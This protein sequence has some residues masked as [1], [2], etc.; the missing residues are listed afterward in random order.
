MT[1]EIRLPLIETLQILREQKKNL[2]LDVTGYSM[3]PTLQ[4]GDKIEVQLCSVEL[5]SSY[6]ILVY[7]DSK[8]NIAVHRLITQQEISVYQR[9]DAHF[10]GS[11]IL[12]DQVLGK[13]LSIHRAGKSIQ[14]NNSLHQR[15]QRLFFIGINALLVIFHRSL[16]LFHFINKF[17]KFRTK[18]QGNSNYW[19]FRQTFSKKLKVIYSSILQ[20]VTKTD[21]WMET[22]TS[23]ASEKDATKNTKTAN[24]KERKHL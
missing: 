10:T 18:K 9:G 17:L 8:Q 14:L 21:S 6:D 12:K 15:K 23:L 7:W 5:L 20:I 1:K 19:H 4:P 16:P 13:V 11:W 3:Y 22:N 24:D 2:C